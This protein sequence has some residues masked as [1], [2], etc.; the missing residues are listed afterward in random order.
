M[1]DDNDDDDAL[2]LSEFKALPANVLPFLSDAELLHQSLILIRPCWDDL[3]RR[4]VPTAEPAFVIG[5]SG[6]GKTYFLCYFIYRWLKGSLPVAALLPTAPSVGNL[7]EGDESIQAL[8]K[9]VKLASE[10]PSK[11]RLPTRE[12]GPFLVLMPAGIQ[13]CIVFNLSMSY[14]AYL[15]IGEVSPFCEL[16]ETWLLVDSRRPIRRAACRVVCVASPTKIEHTD[17]YQWLKELQITPWY[18]L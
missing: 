13:G 15:S 16:P 14:C 2:L 4:I 17:I 3:I 8:R 12:S 10:S 11:S 9:R 18:D 7:D 6:I 1:I 5:N